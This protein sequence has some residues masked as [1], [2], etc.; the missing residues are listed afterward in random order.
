MGGKTQL[1][2]LIWVRLFCFV[3]FWRRGSE[4]WGFNKANNF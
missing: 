4:N 2:R 1:G 3:N